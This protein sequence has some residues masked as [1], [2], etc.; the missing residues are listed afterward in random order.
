MAS[1]LIGH[2]NI[3][4]SSSTGQFLM[5]IPDR[6]PHQLIQYYQ[7]SLTLEHVFREM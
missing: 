2:P 7:K 3:T 1:V 6:Y 5:A 4:H